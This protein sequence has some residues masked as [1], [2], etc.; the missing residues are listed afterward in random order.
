MEYVSFLDADLYVLSSYCTLLFT[1]NVASWSSQLYPCYVSPRP[2][3]PDLLQTCYT[4][5]TQYGGVESRGQPDNRVAVV[6]KLKV[7]WLE[8]HETI[9][10]VKKHLLN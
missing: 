4:V 1:H 8:N 9:S 6:G 2:S 10:A 5:Q 7:P 3:Q